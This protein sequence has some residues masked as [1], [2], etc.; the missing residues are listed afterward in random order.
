MASNPLSYRNLMQYELGPFPACPPSKSYSAA[1]FFGEPTIAR[2]MIPRRVNPAPQ[3]VSNMTTALQKLIEELGT[4]GRLPP[5]NFDQLV[6]N[7]R[8][9]T[10]SDLDDIYHSDKWAKSLFMPFSRPVKEVVRGLAQA[11]GFDVRIRDCP[12]MR[13]RHQVGDGYIE[14]LYD[15][16]WYRV[17]YEIMSPQSLAKQ[18]AHFQ[19]SLPLYETD[20]A[21]S[22]LKGAK[23]IAAKHLV[24]MATAPNYVRD[25]PVASCRYGFITSYTHLVVTEKGISHYSSNTLPIAHLNLVELEDGLTLHASPTFKTR[26]SHHDPQ[27][28][29]DTV[30]PQTPF[31]FPFT[32]FVGTIAAAVLFSLPPFSAIP[33]SVAG[34]DS[35][36]SEHIGEIPLGQNGNLGYND[37]ASIEHE[38][39]SRLQLSLTYGYPLKS[40]KRLFLSSQEPN[41]TV[42]L[43]F[44]GSTTRGVRFTIDVD[45]DLSTSVPTSAITTQTSH[46]R[47]RAFDAQVILE[48]NSPNHFD[49][50]TLCIPPSSHPPDITI[51]IVEEIGQGLSGTAW[52]VRCEGLEWSGPTVLKLFFP[53]AF[54]AVARETFLFEHIFKTDEAVSRLVPQYFGTFGGYDGAWFGIL[55]EDVGEPI[56]YKSEVD[57]EIAKHVEQLL[58]R[59]RVVHGDL[60]GPNVLRDS[61]GALRVID[62]GKAAFLADD[63]SEGQK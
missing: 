62:F 61:K 54:T 13:E 28:I 6:E 24:Q 58:K 1:E 5:H 23:A 47:G 9:I 22:R 25:G 55:M 59:V 4:Q 3:L 63:E 10:E 7:I 35:S 42:A 34:G 11:L 30:P 19:Q 60:R 15:G 40:S 32:S 39:E 16:T 18:A 29:P 21:A 49:F 31:D 36:T 12:A 50:P 53:E 41:Q 43:C 45:T 2:K 52:R 46:P 20:T 17:A 38:A 57:P 26:K 48:L 37:E 8:H 33:P 51:H 56:P 14:V 44:N 27:L